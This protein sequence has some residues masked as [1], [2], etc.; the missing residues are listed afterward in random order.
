MATT[1]RQL[2]QPGVRERVLE[3]VRGLLEELGSLGAVAELSV[4]SNL[5]RD[6]GLGSLERV[7]LLTRLEQAFD[8]R[9]PDTL[10]AEASTPEELIQAIL[11]APGTPASSE[12]D[13]SGLRETLASATAAERRRRFAGG[14]SGDARG[15]DSPSRHP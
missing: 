1:L 7:E 12:N 9:L 6:L 15:S 2:D 13:L 4:T 11:V 14:K 10:T 8:L 5:D 3:V